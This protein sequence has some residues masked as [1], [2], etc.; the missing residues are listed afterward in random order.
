MCESALAG[1]TDRR[2]SPAD[3]HAVN[4]AG[5]MGRYKPLH[6]LAKMI[7]RRLHTDGTGAVNDREAFTV[8]FWLDMHALFEKYVEARLAQAEVTYHSQKAISVTN[9]TL[10]FRCKPDFILGDGFAVLDA[11]YKAILDHRIDEDGAEGGLKSLLINSASG[12]NSLSYI[13]SKTIHAD[14]YRVI[15]YSLLIT[16][17]RF[18]PASVVC[19]VVPMLSSG[20][21]KNEMLRE[22]FAELAKNDPKA[23]QDWARRSCPYFELPL[24]SGRVETAEPQECSNLLVAVLPCYLPTIPGMD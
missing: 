9:G 21:N 24:L 20:S 8:P 5:F 14:Y 17:G 19:L 1:V 12:D 16:H 22:G 6:R 13:V 18:S 7:L 3:F 2:I 23:F 4:Y 15:A 11:K 10:L